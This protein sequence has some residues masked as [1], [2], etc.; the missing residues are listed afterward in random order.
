MLEILEKNVEMAEFAGK[1]KHGSQLKDFEIDGLFNRLKAVEIKGLRWRIA[2]HALGRLQDKKINATYQ[3]IVS[4]IHNSSII[5]Y[6]I[7]ENKIVGGYE[8]RV[9]LRS[10]AMVNR[11]F[12]LHAVYSLTE[13]RIITVW[14]NHKS[15]FHATL[16]WSIYDE[17]MKVFGV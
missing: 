15:D 13:R 12:H 7:D 11:D 17:D 9:V 1:R 10:T 5:E 2:G 8:E 3:D 16:D 6:K 4:T 14:I